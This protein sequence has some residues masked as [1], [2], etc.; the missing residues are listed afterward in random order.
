MPRS[1]NSIKR[2]REI[3]QAMLDRCA[4]PPKAQSKHVRRI[5]QKI[6]KTYTAYVATAI[7]RRWLSFENFV[8]DMG[9]APDGCTIWRLDTSKNYSKIN[10]IWHLRG[11]HPTQADVA[12]R[13]LELKRARQKAMLTDRAQT[14]KSHV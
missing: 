8:A 1:K 2:T 6:G 7:T 10:C 13:R 3:W 5:V 9:Y 14:E 11:N 4:A 12:Q